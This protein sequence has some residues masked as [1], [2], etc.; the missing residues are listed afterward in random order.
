MGVA[1][2]GNTSRATLTPP[3]SVCVFVLL[4]LLG[5]YQPRRQHVPQADARGQC[6]PMSPTPPRAFVH[7]LL[8]DLRGT[9]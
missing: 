6:D 9:L 3:L 1:H 4:L 7:T 5:H 2:D 8:E